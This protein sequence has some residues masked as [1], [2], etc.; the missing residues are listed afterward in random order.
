MYV[1][2]KQIKYFFSFFLFLFL[3]YAINIYAFN[4][5]NDK[6]RV[7]FFDVGQGD[8]IFIQT[9]NNKDILIDGGPNRSVLEKL[10]DSMLF[11]DKTIDIIIITHAHADHIS[12]VIEV[13]KRY[14]VNEIYYNGV[15]YNSDIYVELLK[16]V[17]NRNIKLNVVDGI[18]EIDIGGDISL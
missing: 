1:S 9:P 5:D 17:N 7:T 8:S 18:K 12:G 14:K 15:F 16:Q 10:G 6:L 4:K 3:S 2:N 11:Y 13:L